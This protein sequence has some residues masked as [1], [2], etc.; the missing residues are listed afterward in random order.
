VALQEQRAAEAFQKALGGQQ[1]DTTAGAPPPPPLP[2]RKEVKV[3]A[4]SAP[5][6]AQESSLPVVERLPG[7]HAAQTR[8]STG[9]QSVEA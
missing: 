3:K 4:S 7:G 5:A 6:Q 9:P 2:A 1:P 8:S